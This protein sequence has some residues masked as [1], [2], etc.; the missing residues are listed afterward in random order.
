M[1]N[2]T[3]RLFNTNYIFSESMIE[4]SSV[5]TL[6]VA[7]YLDDLRDLQ[8]SDN[9]QELEN[10][11]LSQPFDNF[12][13]V[14]DLSQKPY[15]DWIYNELITERTNPYIY[16]QYPDIL[17]T[18]PLI[19]YFEL[20]DIIVNIGV[21]ISRGLIKCFD[22][23]NHYDLISINMNI[24]RIS[25]LYLLSRFLSIDRVIDYINQLST[26]SEYNQITKTRQIRAKYNYLKDIGYQIFETGQIFST[27]ILSDSINVQRE[28]FGN[29]ITNFILFYLPDKRGQFTYK[30]IPKIRFNILYEKS[31]YDFFR[32]FSIK[33]LKDI[34]PETFHVTNFD[35]Q[36]ISYF[37]VVIDLFNITR[38]NI[39]GLSH[40]DPL[41]YIYEYIHPISHKRY[42]LA[43]N[44][45][46]I[47]TNR[48]LTFDYNDYDDTELQDYHRQFPIST[49]IDYST[50]PDI[51]S[52]NISRNLKPIMTI[53]DLSEKNIIYY[54]GDMIIT[55]SNKSIYQ[56][57]GGRKNDFIVENIFRILKP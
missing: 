7:I 11:D 14:F 22:I 47:K 9:P 52:R 43:S 32:E 18:I 55:E 45:Y 57:G 56:V 38:K 25:H 12:A 34:I 51:N 16:Y 27:F 42:Y 2:F 26:F 36:V 4:K 21:M 20:N 28:L 33:T 19:N 6:T 50:N 31:W 23:I 5:L 39:N 1:V 3:F 37:I 35:L 48:F 8:D 30:Q 15:W 49:P 24:W 46:V 41:T 13:N 10:L 44:S 40:F 53:S 17:F 29:H 54:S